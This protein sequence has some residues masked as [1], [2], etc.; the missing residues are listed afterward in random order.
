MMGHRE[1]LKNGTEWDAFT[2]WR[3]FLRWKRGVLRQIKTKFNRR[4]RR[5]AKRV[6]REDNE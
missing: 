6:L 1:P 4:I 3:R 5:E 2:G